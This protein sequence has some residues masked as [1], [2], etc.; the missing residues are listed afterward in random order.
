MQA[1]SVRSSMSSVLAIYVRDSHLIY[2]TK[3]FHHLINYFFDRRMYPLLQIR[4][5]M[6]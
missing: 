2:C 3:A 4:N 6:D 1:K 5:E